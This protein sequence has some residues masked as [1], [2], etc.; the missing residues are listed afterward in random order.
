MSNALPKPDEPLS[1]VRE[2]DAVMELEAII[3][4]SL[5][6][7]VGLPTTAANDLAMKMVRV[8]RLRHGGSGVYIPAT[9]KAE[10]DA[11]I[12]AELRPGNAAEVATRHGLSIRAVYKIANRRD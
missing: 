6:I 11:A 8:I 9:N 7:S 4:E 2:A 12:R 3:C 10:R 1:A 5:Q